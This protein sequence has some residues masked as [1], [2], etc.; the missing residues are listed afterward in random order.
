MVTKA[1]SFTLSNLDKFPLIASENLSSIAIYYKCI[2]K[3]ALVYTT[4]H[5]HVYTRYRSNEY[6]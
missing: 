5:V 4:I 2:M 3:N 1:T 6:K